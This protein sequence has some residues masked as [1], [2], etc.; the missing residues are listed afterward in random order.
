[1]INKVNLSIKIYLIAKKYRTKLIQVLLILNKII[2][3]QSNQNIENC[4]IMLKN[5]RLLL[6]N[7]Q[8][9]DL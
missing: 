5:L 4:Q 8:M 6:T 3:L 1:M 9:V 2:R 7:H